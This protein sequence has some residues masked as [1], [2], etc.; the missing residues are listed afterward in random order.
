[1]KC[2][3]IV[4]RMDELG[5]VVIPKEI[6]KT[7]KLK[8]GEA[9]EFYTSQE[10]IVLRKYV[11]NVS[12]QWHEA[13]VNYLALNGQRHGFIQYHVTPPVTTCV[14]FV[15]KKK[16]VGLAYRNPAD[17]DDPTIGMAVALCRALNGQDCDY[18]EIM[19]LEG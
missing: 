11:E 17:V 9:V 15:G 3:G 8:E 5:R 16:Y 14:R 13:C 1:M 19:G 7:M 6:R 12:D 18:M 10:G 4:R 2:T